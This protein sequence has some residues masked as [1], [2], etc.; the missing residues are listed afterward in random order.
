MEPKTHESSRPLGR[1]LGQAAAVSAIFERIERMDSSTKEARLFHKFAAKSRPA[2]N[3]A[4]WPSHPER[5]S[6]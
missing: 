2:K 4:H 6:C 1:L 3:I 5:S